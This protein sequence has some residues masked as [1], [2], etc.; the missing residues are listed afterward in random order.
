VGVH[1]EALEVLAEA[2]SHSSEADYLGVEW[3]LICGGNRAEFKLRQQWALEDV[4]HPDDKVGWRYTE[5]WAHIARHYGPHSDRHHA[6][7]C[8]WLHDRPYPQ[9]VS[10]GGGSGDAGGRARRIIADLDWARGLA[11]LGLREHE[12]EKAMSLSLGWAPREEVT[13]A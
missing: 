4:L 6:C 3:A 2:S 9:T 11:P 13:P 8:R 12:L 1:R 10:G 7:L 5:M